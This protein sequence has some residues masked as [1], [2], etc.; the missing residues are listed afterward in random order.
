[1]DDYI[2]TVEEVHGDRISVVYRQGER[3]PVGVTIMLPEDH[4]PDRAELRQMIE[5]H[6]GQALHFW[7]QQRREENL[8]P[9]KERLMAAL[10]NVRIAGVRR[11]GRPEGG[12]PD[13]VEL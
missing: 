7:D 10:G 3:D 4:E 2:A 11:T 1:M 9:R 12:L 6:A 13:V 5:D 8:A